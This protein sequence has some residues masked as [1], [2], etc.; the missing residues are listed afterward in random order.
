MT[1]ITYRLAQKRNIVTA[2]ARID[3]RPVGI[4]ANNPMFY[5]GILDYDVDQV[6]LIYGSLGGVIATLIFFYL[7]NFIFIYGAELNYQ[8][9]VTF[10]RRPEEKEA[11]MKEFLANHSQILVAT[12]VI[13]VGVDVPNATVMV[14]ENAERF[15]LSQLHQLRGRIGRGASES[16]C[17][18]MASH[19]G[20]PEII[21]R[22]RALE[23]THDG[24][25][26]AEIDL[27]MRGSGEFFGT[28]QS[29]LPDFQ[30][31][32]LPRDFEWLKLARKD[33]FE[34]VEII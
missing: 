12:T 3:G 22:L 19:F 18:L 5:G 29:G 30:M 17:F 15:G 32:R 7:I 23:T 13:E 28:K 25:K 27:E 9:A 2:L 16:F 20:T 14:V 33:A 26:L 34:L 24:F 31:G 6:N 11:V 4:V 8:L 21:Q 10:E 1:D